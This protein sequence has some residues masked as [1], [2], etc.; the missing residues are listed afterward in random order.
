MLFNV[1]RLKSSKETAM[2]ESNCVFNTGLVIIISMTHHSTGR[3][4]WLKKDR[5]LLR[6]SWLLWLKTAA[7]RCGGFSQTQK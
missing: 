4:C 1:K 6:E 2:D 5:L 7:G 3:K